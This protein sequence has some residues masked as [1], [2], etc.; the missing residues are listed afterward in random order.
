MAT[1]HWMFLELPHSTGGLPSASP[2]WELPRQVGQFSALSEVATKAP[3]RIS[4]QEN[5]IVSCGY[6]SGKG[7]RLLETNHNGIW[8]QDNAGFRKAG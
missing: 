3:A 6:Q 5:F 7:V 4:F 2:A 1:F 8:L